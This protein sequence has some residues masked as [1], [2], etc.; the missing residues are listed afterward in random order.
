MPSIQDHLQTNLPEA[1]DYRGSENKSQHSIFSVI[2]NM[3]LIDWAY[4]PLCINVLENKTD[5]NQSTDM[6]FFVE[7]EIDYVI[8]M[9]KDNFKKFT[10]TDAMLPFYTKAFETLKELLIEQ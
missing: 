2:K 1:N 8:Q 5:F 10:K 7:M 9:I 6:R 4:T 3:P